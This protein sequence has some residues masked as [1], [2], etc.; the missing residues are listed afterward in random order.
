METLFSP[1][2][3]YESP[4]WTELKQNRRRFLTQQAVDEYLN[5]I[6]DQLKKHSTKPLLGKRIYHV[7]RL[8]FEIRRIMNG[9]EP[10]IFFG[11]GR[12]KL[13]IGN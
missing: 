6:D 3:S 1:N 7:I 11:W 10:K 9:E 4:C 2:F 5:Y 13:L 8:L 12:E